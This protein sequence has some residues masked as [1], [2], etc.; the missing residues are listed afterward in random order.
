MLL[1]LACPL[2]VLGFLSLPDRPG[3]PRYCREQFA[4]AL[5]AQFA[6][7]VTDLAKGALDASLRC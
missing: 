4:A 5:V 1:A 7:R 3:A 6:L 2:F